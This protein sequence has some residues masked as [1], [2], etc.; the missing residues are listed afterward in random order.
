MFPSQ[1]PGPTPTSSDEE[2]YCRVRNASA[3]ISRCAH[4]DTSKRLEKGG[5]P[6][7]G[8][9]GGESTRRKMKFNFLPK[10]TALRRN[11]DS[12]TNKRSRAGESDKVSANGSHKSDANFREGN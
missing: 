3:L 11:A 9:G 2:M 5:V 12:L 1:K 8:K 4:F 10:V 6:C 7:A